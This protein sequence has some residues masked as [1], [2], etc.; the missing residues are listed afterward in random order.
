[1]KISPFHLPINSQQRFIRKQYWLTHGTHADL[2]IFACEFEREAYDDSLFSYYDIAPLSNVNHCATKR[3]AEYLAGRYCIAN[4]FTELGYPATT[5]K[6]GDRGQPLWP[7]DIVGAITHN[8]ASAMCAVK[9]RTSRQ[10]YVGIDKEDWIGE[11]ETKLISTYIVNAIEFQYLKSILFPIDKLITITFSAK[12]SIFKAFSYEVGTF[13]DFKEV[14]LSHISIVNSEGYL[15]LNTS[16]WLQSRATI[17][18]QVK[19]F[20]SLLPSGVITLFHQ[21]HQTTDTLR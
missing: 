8:H 11:A 5:I 2:C 15:I 13:F 1:M 21:C 3:K 9:Q 4:A 19:V 14:T 17:G 10:E 18:E 12:E 7:S 16:E 6:Q 20:F